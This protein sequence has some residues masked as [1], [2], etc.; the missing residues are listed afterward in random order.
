MVTVHARGGDVSL[1]QFQTPNKDFSLMQTTWARQLNPIIARPQN[2]STILKN[3]SLTTGDNSIKHTLNEKLQGWKIVRIRAAA[4]I[5][6]KQDD[7]MSP[8]VFLILNSSAD[9]V[10]DLEVF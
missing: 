6:D 5:Y 7:N 3:I 1:P 4:T 8:S 10:I 9:V 2:N